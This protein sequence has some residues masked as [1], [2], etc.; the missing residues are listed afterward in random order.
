MNSWRR[1]YPICR[2]RSTERRDIASPERPPAAETTPQAGFERG[3][4]ETVVVLAAEGSK[5]ELSCEP[6]PTQPARSP[7][8]SGTERHD[9]ER[10]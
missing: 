3:S 6:G 10:R 4:R 7:P 1:R 2:R 9:Q 5:G 8:E